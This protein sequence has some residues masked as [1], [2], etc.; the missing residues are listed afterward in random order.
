MAVSTI[1]A[2]PL[3]YRNDSV[4]KDLVRGVDRGRITKIKEQA[5]PNSGIAKKTS[6][7]PMSALGQKQT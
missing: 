6:T 5:A 7:G 4:L 3:R 2:E 1:T